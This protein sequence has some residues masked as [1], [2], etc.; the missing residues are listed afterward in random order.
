MRNVTHEEASLDRKM[1]EVH[2]SLSAWKPGTNCPGLVCSARQAKC[3]MGLNAGLNE[4]KRAKTFHQSA[5][6]Q[7]S[8]F[9]KLPWNENLL[10]SSH[11]YLVCVFV[12]LNVY[13]FCRS[14]GIYK[15]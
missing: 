11:P 3:F 14:L 1:L 9:A 15:V 4:I 8:V 10:I 12:F 6:L 7:A 2:F 13:S 5:D